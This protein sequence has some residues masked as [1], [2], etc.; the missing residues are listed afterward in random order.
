M[1]YKYSNGYLIYDN[2]STVTLFKKSHV[3]PH[4]YHTFIDRAT[5][6]IQHFNRL[7]Y[8][9]FMDK[10]GRAV[11]INTILNEFNIHKKIKYISKYKVW[12][13]ELIYTI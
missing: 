9:N 3:Y 2:G 4:I 11:E 5:I 8:C 1:V 6:K 10:M 13:G 7:K 12:H